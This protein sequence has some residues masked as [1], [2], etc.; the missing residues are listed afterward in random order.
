MP[1]PPRGI[2]GERLSMD[3]SEVRG[4]PPSCIPPPSVLPRN[5]NGASK[6]QRVT[7]V[8]VH[9]PLARDCS[10][11]VVCACEAHENEGVSMSWSGHVP[12]IQVIWVNRNMPA[13]R[14][15][16]A[17]IM[18]YISRMTARPPPR[19]DRGSC[20][21][22]AYSRKHHDDDTMEEALVGSPAG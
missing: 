2:Q 14:Q 13:K 17:P 8:E 5:T 11:V 22:R 10:R 21:L 18:G 6:G 15:V 20:Y 12:G 16:Y 3:G 7:E 1:V 9:Y 4:S 19:G